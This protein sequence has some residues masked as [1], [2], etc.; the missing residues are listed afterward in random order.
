MSTVKVKDTFDFARNFWFMVNVQIYF[1][2]FLGSELYRVTWLLSFI[3]E[4]KVL[5]LQTV[6]AYV[7]RNNGRVSVLKPQEK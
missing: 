4:H 5:S 7:S 2:C 6:I 3:S 1:V